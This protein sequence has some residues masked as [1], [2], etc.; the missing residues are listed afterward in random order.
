MARKRRTVHRGRRPKRG[1][2]YWSLGKKIGVIFG[3]TLIT[4]L[5]LSI[6]AGAV[7]ISGKMERLDTQKL[8]T[9]A[10]EINSEVARKEGYLNVALFGVDSR[11]GNLSSGDS[12]SDTIMVA[13]LNQATGEVKLVSVYRD[14]LLQQDDGTYNKANAAYSFGGPEEAIAM[15]NKNLDLDITHYITVDFNALVDVIDDLGGVELDLTEEEVYWTNGYCN[16][17]SKVTGHEMNLLENP[18]KQVLNGVQATSY[19]RIRY[20]TGDDYKRTERQRNVLEQIATKAQ[21]ADLATINKIINDVFDEISTNFTLAEILSYAK[22]FMTYSMGETSGFPFDVT[23]DTLGDIGSCVI[24]VDLADNVKQLHTFLYGTD[25][26]Y[27][28]SS[29]VK[30]I[31][32]EINN[33]T[34]LTY[35]EDSGEYSDGT[36]TNTT[37]DDSGSYYDSSSTYN[38]TGTYDSTGSGTGTYDSSPN[39]DTSGGY[40]GGYDSTGDSAG[41]YDSTGGSTGAST[42]SY[43]T[44]GTYDATGGETYSTG[45]DSVTGY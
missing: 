22:G 33:Q 12:R 7:Y 3:G 32:E 2:R 9:S 31:S 20:T 30:T 41:T 43:N 14:T 29:T 6:V 34:N 18:G 21:Q 40:T 4:V 10:L 24:P 11:D 35:G 17:T 13:S 16:E 23:S 44:T 5:V 38:S 8:D 26:E 42:E 15:L 27:S 28:V 45:T 39:G 36:S 25:K 1:F 37:Y 19:C